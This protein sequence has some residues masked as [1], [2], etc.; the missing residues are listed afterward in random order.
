MSISQPPQLLG[1]E[2]MNTKC[3]FLNISSCYTPECFLS[4]DLW[5]QFHN[6]SLYTLISRF[7]FFT[8][9]DEQAQ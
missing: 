4:K 5:F 7:T 2:Y 3:H 1:S 8:I 9:V 6:I